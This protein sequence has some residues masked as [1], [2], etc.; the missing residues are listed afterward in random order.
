MSAI[1]K[2][3][4]GG[5]IIIKEGDSG[6]TFFQLLEGKAKVFKN[7]GQDDQVEIATLDQGQ[8]FGEMAVIE[9]YPRSTTVIA[10]GDAKVLEIA[11]EELGDYFTQ[12][13]DKIIEIMR[14]LATRIKTMADDYK[15]VKKMLDSIHKSDSSSAYDGFFKMMQKQS[16]F[17][18][19][20]S[21]RLEKPSV[22]ELLKAGQLVAQQSGS[23]E[24][25]PYGTV[26][27][28]EG[29]VG[30]CMYIVHEGEVNVY[31]NYG[32]ADEIKLDSV[33]PIACF[34]ELGLL[35]GEPR[36]ATAAVEVS[37]TKIEAIRPED[38]ESIFKTSP[39][40][41]EMI[42]KNL[43]YRLRVI[44]YDYFKACKEIL[45]ASQN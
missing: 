17:V 33:K 25:F 16:I 19:P 2:T 27:Y 10:D 38:L 37:G 7:Y 41:I 12:N 1:E 31:K 9:T 22:E 21:M 29:E 20:K 23:A 34:G 42:L 8:Y 26:M 45:E 43:S 15:E 44:T 40:K 35:S 3:F 5:E 32:A 13:P 6:N 30:N 14:L 24:E 11:A 36:E 4:A 39:E 28:K 18:A